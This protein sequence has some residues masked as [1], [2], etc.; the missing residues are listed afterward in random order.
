MKMV[1]SGTNDQHFPAIYYMKDSR[2]VTS[3]K[4]E[5][6]IQIAILEALY[7]LNYEDAVFQEGLQ[8]NSRYIQFTAYRL[9]K[10]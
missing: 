5:V 2:R 4:P 7:R 8:S 9:M 6:D 10:K 3:E 1:P